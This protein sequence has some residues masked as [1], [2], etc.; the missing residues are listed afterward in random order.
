M[1]KP[2]PMQAEVLKYEGGMMGVAAVPGSGKTATLSA[3]A[4]QLIMQGRIYDNQE[5]LIVT[6]VNSAVDNFSI[7]IGDFIRE[8]GLLDNLGYRVRTLHGLA[9]D[10]VRERPDLA[11]LSDQFSILDENDTSHMIEEISTAYL[12]EHPELTI[13]YIDP[14]IDLSS[15]PKTQKSWYETITSINANFISQAKDLQIEPA[16]IREKIE[17]YHLSD[18]LL[19]MALE[20]YFDYQ[21]GLR[22]RGS[23]DFSDLVRLAHRVLSS[24]PEFLER[25]RYRWPYVLE[26]EAQDSSLVQEKI[27]RLLVGPNGNWVRVGDTNQA[28]YETFTTASPKFLQNFLKEKR[29]D[30]K[31][32]ANSGRS[33]KS[34]IR[35]ANALNKWTRDQ[36]P[37]D[38]L[39]SSLTLPLIVP[40]PP[41]DP[42]PNPQDSANSIFIYKSAISS[43]EEI[44]KVVESLKSWVPANPEK[45]VA[46]LC[47]IG[48]HAEKVVE[49]LQSTEI[50]VVEMLKSTQSTRRVTRLFEKILLSLA[51]PSAVNKLSVVFQLLTHDDPDLEPQKD[52]VFDLLNQVKKVRQLE[53]LLYTNDLA[54]WRKIIQMSE[55]PTQLEDRFSKFLKDMV[56]WQNATALPIDQLILTIGRDLFTT[57]QD[58]ALTHKLALLLEFSSR[59]HPDYQ[60][61]QFALDLAEI[62]S[63]ER[64]FAGF[65]DD[66]TGFNP[67]AHKG[68]VLVTTFH[69]AKGLEWDRVYLLSVNNY[70][71]PSAQEFDLYKGEKWF[72][73]HHYN[74]EA[75]LLAKLKALVVDDIP[76]M[77]MEAGVATLQARIEYSAERLRLLYVG[78]TRA[79]ENLIITWNTG[80]RKEPARMALP[81]EALNAILEETNVAA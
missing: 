67:E 38:E 6:L 75:E 1:F 23:V 9:H 63:N 16:E 36:H 51:D 60:L 29:V 31:D 33:N 47:P 76:G 72:I 59:N 11:G 8:A 66:D 18:P 55:I 80:K 26:D 40:A 78:I 57:P 62:S 27:L 2:R 12:R 77:F 10:I 81:L 69:K 52:K 25:L 50:E 73:A 48:F 19:D 20:V 13:K 41:G 64:K 71:F 37:V 15:E 21:R 46:V 58:L 3:L 65:S 68:K 56:R 49:A 42:Q 45:T 54:D 7:K 35:L 4:A 30:A 17:K 5:I 32:L 70:D 34:I 28:I 22:Y 74:L 14:S 39:R 61:P 24:D 43:D 79:R 44:K 53:D